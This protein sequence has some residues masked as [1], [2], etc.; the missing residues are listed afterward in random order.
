MNRPEKRVEGRDLC[1]EAIRLFDDPAEYF[2]M[3]EANGQVMPRELLAAMQEEGLKYRFETLVEK[4]PMLE[5]LAGKQGITKIEN[6]DD[7]VPLLFEHTMYK[8]YPPVLL[9]QSRFT[10]LNKFISRL[11]VHDL[12]DVDV[13]HCQSIDEWIDVL[14]KETELYVAFSSGTSGVMS[15]IPATRREWVTRIKQMKASL[16]DHVDDPD[17]EIYCVYPFFRTGGGHTRMNDFTVEYIVGDEA[18][19]VAAYPGRLSADVLY[20]AARLRAAKAKGKLDSLEITPALLDQVKDYEQ[21]QKDMPAYLDKFFERIKDDMR[22]KRIYF[23][24]TWNMLHNLAKQ[25]LEKG[26][27]AVFAPDSYIQGGGGAKGLTPPDN[28]QGDVCK[29]IGIEK[30]VMAYGMV[31]VGT[32]HYQ[33][34]HGHY[35]FSPAAIPYVLDADTSKPLPR[36]GKQTGRAA[37]FDLTRQDSWGGFITGDEI[38]VNWD[39]ICPCG[40]ESRFIEGDIQRY[41]EKKGGDDKISCAATES[42]HKEAMEYLT[43]VETGLSDF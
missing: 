11:S 18:H 14:D 12:S 6:I 34:E 29:F 19:F 2:D 21:L 28:W 30:M 17:G 32:L 38:T 10:D 5:K 42:A 13:S 37:F 39:D 26:E 31:E 22:G 24:G 4:I 41:T 20:L 36:T 15:F 40:R 23:G 33:C 1:A 25:G 35:H 16:N 9:E 3:S 27:E 43:Q 7:A 8:S